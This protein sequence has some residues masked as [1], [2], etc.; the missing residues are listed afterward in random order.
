MF[1]FPLQKTEMHHH[2][3]HQYAQRQSRERPREGGGH[4]LVSQRV[5]TQ[6]THDYTAG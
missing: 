4:N 3:H 6:E 1:R 2:F 5:L